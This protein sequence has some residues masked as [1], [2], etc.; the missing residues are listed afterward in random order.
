MEKHKQVTTQF[1]Q[2]GQPTRPGSQ[3]SGQLI[4]PT[5]KG[6]N[7]SLTPLQL[8]CKTLQRNRCHRGS[9]QR[10]RGSRLPVP[11]AES[12]S[13]EVGRWEG[14]WWGSEAAVLALGFY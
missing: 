14:S 2:P 13:E 9:V 1:S 6:F 3:K 10:Q 8:M 4:T 7:H 12:V 5:L 11:E